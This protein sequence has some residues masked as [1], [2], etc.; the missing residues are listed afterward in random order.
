MAFFN[1][2]SISGESEN[3][4][5]WVKIRLGGSKVGVELEQEDVEAAMEEAVIEFSS[6]VNT[7]QIKFYFSNILNTSFSSVTGGIQDKGLH[8]RMDFVKQLAKAYEEETA[9]GG[10]GEVYTGY[11]DWQGGQQSMNL[12]DNLYRQDG[13]SVTANSVI[14]LD[15]YYKSEYNLQYSYYDNYYN[16]LNREF[17]FDSLSHYHPTQ[18]LYIFPLWADMMHTNYM[19][20]QI[21][22]RKSHFRYLYAGKKLQIFPQPKA[23]MKIWV[24]FREQESKLDF[25][26]D[27]LVTSIADAPYNNLDYEKINDLSKRWIRKYTLAICKEIL[28]R[29]RGKFDSIPIPERDIGLD[30]DA[31]ISEGKEEQETLKTELGNELAEIT[32]AGI[33]E[34]DAD[35]S[36]N[37]NKQFQYIPLKIGRG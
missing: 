17:G 9:V 22:F 19:K 27:D 18:L 25:Y 13:T 32:L 35:L 8:F 15:V 16:S 31:L 10:I 21:Q 5:N 36:E 6:I 3:V 20:T 1:I 23:D 34:S 7:H 14:L 26:Q 28:G 12:V 29:I 24:K 37:I 4:Y 2:E 33:M 11:V 30:G